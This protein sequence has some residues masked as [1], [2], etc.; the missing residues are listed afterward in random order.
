LA[1][2]RDLNSRD[3]FSCV[4]TTGVEGAACIVSLV[5]LTVVDL[6]NVWYNNQ[7]KQPGENICPKVAAES[8]H[9]PD[10]LGYFQKRV[11][12]KLMNLHRKHV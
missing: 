3:P 1:T 5:K 7:L 10:K 12:Q 4:L 11:R 6:D 8:L 2:G 9:D